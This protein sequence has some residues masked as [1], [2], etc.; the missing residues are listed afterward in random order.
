MRRCAV[1]DPAFDVQPGIQRDQDAD[2]HTEMGVG[3][4]ACKE[5]RER[6]NFGNGIDVPYRSYS[7]VITVMWVRP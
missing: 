1:S 3:T 2:P 4:E 5:V 7:A 6:E